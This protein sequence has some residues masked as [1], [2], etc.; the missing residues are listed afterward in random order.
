MSTPLTPDLSFNGPCRSVSIIQHFDQRSSENEVSIMRTDEVI[1]R[2][3]I[4]VIQ[5]KSIVGTLRFIE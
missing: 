3:E 1:Y 2:R 4:F 5:T